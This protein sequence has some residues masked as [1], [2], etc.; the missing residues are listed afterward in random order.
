MKI[1]IRILLVSIVL[2]GLLLSFGSLVCRAADG[3]GLHVDSFH[4]VPYGI[5][6][7]QG[8]LHMK[9]GYYISLRGV[10]YDSSNTRDSGLE[11]AD[12]RP[13]I[14]GT[15]RSLSWRIE[16]DLVGTDTRRNMYDLWLAWEPCQAFRLKAGQ[17]RVALGSEYTTHDF[18]LPFVGYGF[19]SYLDGRY[20]VGAQADG[21]LWGRWLWYQATAT[22]GNGFGLEGDRIESPLFSLR[23]VTR[24]L[25]WIGD[26]DSFM[27]GLFLGGAFAFLSDFDDPL[28]IT[29]PLE[30]RIF[31][32]PDLDGDSGQ[33]LHLEAGFHY[34]PFMI[35]VEDVSGAANDVPVSAGDDED[36]DQLTTWVAYGSWNITGEEYRWENGG[37]LQP[38]QSGSWP[39]GRWEITVR[40]SNADMDRDLFDFGYTSYGVST[41]ECRAF[42]T[43]LNWYP[44]RYSRVAFGW[45]RTIADDDL[46]T[47]DGDDR[48][49]SF[50]LSLEVHY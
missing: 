43:F 13:I 30:S 15:M 6:F 4:A 32:T 31:T 44:C 34:G 45:V 27:S 41:Q 26:G 19:T 1:L 16:L 49:S 42:S 25:A 23:L 36:F 10:E 37:W 48:D 18:D 35:G 8:D 11:L 46:E 17:F 24:P 28:V 2:S 22:I 33:W 14:E 29:N 40:Y 3:P 50:V 20:D 38:S 39:Y 5:T 7:D 21:E 9:G 12:A 47:F